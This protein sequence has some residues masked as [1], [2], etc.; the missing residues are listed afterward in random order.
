MAIVALLPLAR[1][2]QKTLP[3][4]SS[5]HVKAKKPRQKPKKS[6][7]LP[8]KKENERDSGVRPPLW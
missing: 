2:E 8:T 1:V 3:A 4:P 7:I 6:T 5:N